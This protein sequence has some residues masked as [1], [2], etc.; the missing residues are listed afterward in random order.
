[1]MTVNKILKQL[2]LWRQ[3][4]LGGWIESIGLTGFI[5]L[6]CY[7]LNP[8]NPLFVKASFPWPWIAPLIAVFQYGLGPGILSMLMIVVIAL[9]RTN[10][11]LLTLADCQAYLLSGATLVLL[12][13]LFSAS[14]IRRMLHA[15]L[16]KNYFDERLKSLSQSY[17]TL[18][19]STDYLEQ[20][21]ITK[22]MTLR[23]ALRELQKLNISEGERL[24]IEVADSFLQLISQFCMINI[25]GIYLA[26]NGILEHQIF[27]EI[28]TMGDLVKDDP[29]IK[30]CRL[31]DRLSHVSINEIEDANECTYLVV[32]PLIT[33]DNEFLG[34]L[35]IKEMPFWNLTEESLRILNI[36]V[37][38]FA[39]EVMASAKVA[40]FLRYY[41]DCTVD[42][43]K[44]LTRLIP[45]KI[46]M[47]IDSVLV[48]V[49]IDKKL[50]PHDVIYHLKNQ[51]RLLDSWWSTEIG[52]YD[53]LFVLMPF[54][55]GAG[56]N[57]Y[58]TRIKRYL[59]DELGLTWDNE[60]IKTR[61]TLL[62][63]A[64]PLHLMNNFI[65]FIMGNERV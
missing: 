40:D 10:A 31:T 24:S 58:K 45:L 65:N 36:L 3:H 38:Y 59:K 47:D 61:S 39:E 62:Y 33:S 6:C 44:Q 55:S 32:I 15:E 48:A 53:V 26:K 22:P 46:T 49:M 21:I 14:W 11:G 4:N 1:M 52:N 51:H 34:I 18:R 63:Q 20:N 8:E 12:S 43:A 9:M 35:A 5:L 27:A 41:P 28:G 29:L 37:F 25:A 2:W 56:L 19:V 64:E 16:M 30:K 42:F 60:Q 7:Y 54:T 23:I 50:R 57:G 13:S 17:Y